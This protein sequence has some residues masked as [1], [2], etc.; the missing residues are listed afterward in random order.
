MKIKTAELTGKALCY[1]VCMLEMPHL[2]WGETIGIHHA[3]DQ[4]VVPEL[5]EPLCYSPFMG[6][7]QGGP[8]IERERLSIMSDY[9]EI[10][11]G[12]LGETYNGQAREFGSTPLIAAL[13]CYVADKMGDEVEIP[14]ELL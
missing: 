10:K 6:W 8:V 7:S 9:H 11:K 13:R 1:S 3:S 4:V 2:V 12:W 5:K 14:E